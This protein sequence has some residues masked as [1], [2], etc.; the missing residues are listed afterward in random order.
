MSSKKNVE[1]TKKENK[2][3]EEKKNIKKEEKRKKKEFP[4]P[5]Q[6]KNFKQIEFNEETGKL[7]LIDY[8]NDIFECNIY[9]EKTPKFNL[10]I[11]GIVNYKKREEKNLI[12]KQIIKEPNFYLPITKKFE[13]YFSF[14]NPLSLPFV[15]EIND[16]K[17]LIEEVKKEERF[18]NNSKL[19]K[20]LELKIPSKDNQCLLSYLSSSMSIDDKKI[21]LHLI[22]LIDNYMQEKKKENPFI[23]NFIYKNHSMI[24]LRRFKNILKSN[25]NYNEINGKKISIPKKEF[26]EKYNLMNKII[27][28]QGIK[29]KHLQTENVNFEVYKDLYSIKNVGEENYIFKPKVLNSLG[30]ITNEKINEILSLRKFN[31][32]NPNK[33]SYSLNTIISDQNQTKSTNFDLKFSTSRTK[34]YPS[35]TSLNFNPNLLNEDQENLS[36][37]SIEDDDI[38]NKNNYITCRTYRELNKK[39]DKES[40]LLKGFQYP[41]YQEPPIFIKYKN[42]LKNSKDLYINDINL[43]KKVNPI[44]YKREEEKNLLDLKMLQ[45]KKQNQLVFERIKIKK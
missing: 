4:L 20:I 22:Q 34:F 19:N 31:E 35:Q 1:K 11:S 26:K 38:I 44:A 21:K 15:N 37:L 32:T 3:E 41:E 9:G 10:N 30:N 43:L 5:P 16:P 24:A 23:E 6:P 27:K 36:I 28:K 7:N 12:D 8:N 18:K 17:Y 29:N 39:N 13:G 14:P 40:K 42:E 25:L 2:K 33:T 45:K